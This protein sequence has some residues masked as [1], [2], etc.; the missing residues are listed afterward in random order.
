MKNAKKAIGETREIKDV[1]KKV[2]DKEHSAEIS[3][4]IPK[5]V[6]DSSKVPKIILDQDSEYEIFSNAKDK[7][8][9]EF[10]LKFEVKKDDV[11]A[12]PGKPTLLIE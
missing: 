6:K 11:K 1:I 9:K 5:L 8:E 4:I 7:L 3:K 2:M 10:N 12:M